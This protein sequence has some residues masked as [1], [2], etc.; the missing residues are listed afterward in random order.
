MR[1]EVPIPEAVPSIDTRPVL[2]GRGAWSNVSQVVQFLVV[3][4]L[5]FISYW[6]ISHYL[7]Q[8][9]KVV[10]VSMSPTLHD[11]EGYLLNRWVL[12][13]RR[14]RR[15]DIV[16]LRDPLDN[17]YSVKRVV[18]LAGD[19][20]CLKEG[21][22]FLNGREIEEPYLRSGTPT[23]PA[24]SVRQQSFTCGADQFFLLGDNRNNSVDSRVYGPVPRA[25]ILGLVIH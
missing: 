15:A 3:G 2:A 4:F 22:V 13:L 16:V 18:G 17:G 8:S 7:L 14:P 9:V 10:G 11:S 24:P 23:F 6:V 12:H 25:N 1:A 19:V 20:I 5:A 21:R